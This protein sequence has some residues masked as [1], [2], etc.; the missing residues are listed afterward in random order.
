[1]GDIKGYGGQWGACAA[2]EYVLNY[3]IDE[4]AD[5]RAKERI[6][7]LGWTT[8]WASKNGGIWGII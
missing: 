7:L 6:S 4:K 8:Y 1:M 5:S 2:L 3:R